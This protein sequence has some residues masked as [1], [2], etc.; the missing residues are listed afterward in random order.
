MFKNKRVHCRICGKE[1]E[2]GY[3]PYRISPSDHMFISSLLFLPVGRLFIKGADVLSDEMAVLFIVL[4]M[5]PFT[6]GLYLH[7]F[8]QIKDV[9]QNCMA[10]SI[11]GH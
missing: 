2:H 1:V 7:F 3:R 9:C 8:G 11:T 10:M 6:W 4:A 5:L